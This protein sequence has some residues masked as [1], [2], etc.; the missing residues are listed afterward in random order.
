MAQ[1]Q[2]MLA[3]LKKELH[4]RKG[5]LAGHNIQTVYFGGGTPSVLSAHEIG[6]LL[7]LIDRQ[8]SLHAVEEITL[9]GNPDDLTLNKLQGFRQA[10]INRLSIGIQSFNDQALQYMNRAHNA[11]DA[12]QC[13]NNAQ[14]TGF[15][16]YSLDL[17][18]AIPVL[19]HVAWAAD[20]DTLLAAKPKHISA[21]CLTIE[22]GT[23]FGHWLKQGKLTPVDDGQAADQLLYLNK[24]LAN[25]GYEH[26]EVSNFALPGWLSKH[27]SSYWQQKPY[28]GIGP[29][30]HSYNGR[31]RLYAV[32]NNSKY[33]KQISAGTL[34]LTEEVL[35]PVDRANELLLTGLRTKWGC[36]LSQV[37]Q[38][39][40]IDLTQSRGDYL[41]QLVQTGYANMNNQHL[42]LTELGLSLAD[43]ITAQL[44]IDPS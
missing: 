17:I 36:S 2:P 41:Q 32:S 8:Y 29:S 34:P 15:S 40:G 3:A 31:N 25:G 30:A 7:N 42:V 37:Q 14:A 28:L 20:V 12:L 16:N 10:G 5:F 39:T 44:F 6:E 13:I 19:G 24:V 22:D 33:I 27:N 35:T 38:L 9:E 11:S 21:Y 4:M 26:Y 18:Y 1:K 23:A 43:E